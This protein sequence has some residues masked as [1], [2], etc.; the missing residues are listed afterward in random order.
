MRTPRETGPLRLRASGLDA[1]RL[2]LA[3]APRRRMRSWRVL[4]CAG[5]MT[6]AA[7]ALCAVVVLGGWS[8]LEPDAP[9]SEVRGRLGR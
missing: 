3:D 1:A 8:P 2:A 5:L 7:L 6:A 4:A 9:Q